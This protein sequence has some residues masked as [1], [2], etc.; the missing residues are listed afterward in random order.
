MPTYRCPKCGRTVEKPEGIY[1]CKECGPSAVMIKIQGVSSGSS[2]NSLNIKIKRVLWEVGMDIT[3][4][5]RNNEV[6]LDA[7]GH[8][9]VLA[10]VNGTP[11]WLE[12]WA[13]EGGGA[14]GV[15]SK[16]ETPLLESIARDVTKEFIEGLKRRITRWA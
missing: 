2:G 14:F 1:Y 8:L 12:F 10:E 9:Y 11:I 5:W 15:V 16:A 4:L 7:G 6:N 3:E 13:S